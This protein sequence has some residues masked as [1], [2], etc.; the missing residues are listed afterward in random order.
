MKS[1]HIRSLE[2]MFPSLPSSNYAV[3][4]HIHGQTR[5]FGILTNVTNPA[6][7]YILT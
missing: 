4:L 3:Q 6:I 5:S 2:S 7:F 1:V